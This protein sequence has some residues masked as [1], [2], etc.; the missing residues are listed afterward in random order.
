[1][2]VP[3][4]VS[5]E[6]STTTKCLWRRIRDRT[7]AN[8]PVVRRMKQSN[9]GTRTARKKNIDDLENNEKNR[10]SIA[11]VKNHAFLQKRIDTQNMNNVVALVQS[12]LSSNEDDHELSAPVAA[13][14]KSN[15]SNNGRAE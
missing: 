4:G 12:R 2:E 15:N 11:K 3:R 14:Y 6:S 13:V 9:R 7:T 1:M 5:L 10:K 8:E